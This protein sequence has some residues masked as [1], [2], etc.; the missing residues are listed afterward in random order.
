M[1]HYNEH[2]IYDNFVNCFNNVNDC[3]NKP[4]CTHILSEILFITVMA[5][6]A[7]ADDFEGIQDYGDAKVNWLSSFLKLPGGIPRH[8]TFNRVLCGINPKEFESSF[9]SWVSGYLDQ[10]PQN[11]ENDIINLD[12]KTVCNSADT[13]KDKRPIHIVSALSTKYGL[14]LGQQKCHEKSNEITA[15]PALLSLLD[16]KGTLIT[17]DAMGTQ[18]SIAE[19]IIEKG[20]DYLLALKGNQGNLHKEIVDFFKKLE[21]KEFK[22]YIHQEDTEIDKG[23]GRIEERHC[24]TV[25][26]L[27]WL[28]ETQAW[29][30]I[31]SIVRIISKVTKNDKESVEARYYISSL[32]GNASFINRAV[33]KHWHIENKLHWILDVVFKEDYSRVRTGNG[34]ENMSIVRKIALNKIKADKTIK[35]SVK[36][37]RAIAS[38][39]D[40]YALKIFANMMVK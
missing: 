31:K 1:E 26:N 20:G 40:D 37:K 18:K 3:R 35:K 36:A 24:T 28:Y 32:N 16:I 34:A 6:I 38:W 7:G 39:N 29:S 27:D 22:K 8:D 9:I 25:T 21:K 13:Y 11:Q 14:V 33:R 2:R 19:L 15:I 23:H 5:V 12:G 30:G 10:L 17:I 4:Q